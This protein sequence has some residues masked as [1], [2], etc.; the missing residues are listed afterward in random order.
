MNQNY[1]TCKRIKYFSKLDEDMFFAWIKSISCIEKFEAAHDEL[2]LDL[3][4]KELS[5]DDMKNLMA[6]LYRYKINMQQLQ[7][8]ITENNKTAM[9]GWEKQIF[10]KNK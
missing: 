9:K 6:L 10:K 7:P 2:Y 1:I 8:F 5:Y 4:D 3:V